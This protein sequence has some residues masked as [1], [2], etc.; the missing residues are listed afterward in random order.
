LDIETAIKTRIEPQLIKAFGQRTA[1]SLLSMATI[2]YVTTRGTEEER[3]WAF[4]HSI[5]TDDR[6][7]NK[8]NEEPTASWEEDWQDLVAASSGQASDQIGRR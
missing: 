3:C 8:R 7:L 1:N 2:C 4:I 5:C 6:V